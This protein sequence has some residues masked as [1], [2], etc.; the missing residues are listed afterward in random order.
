VL[1]HV[2]PVQVE[3]APL[4]LHHAAADDAAQH[5]LTSSSTQCSL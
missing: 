1:V 2:E 3:E 4:R 5:T